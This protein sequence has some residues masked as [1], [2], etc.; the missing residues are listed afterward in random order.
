MSSVA[1]LCITLQ[2]SSTSIF[3]EKNGI[4]RAIT[5]HK[6]ACEYPTSAEWGSIGAAALL[7]RALRMTVTET[8]RALG[9]VSYHGSWS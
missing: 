9:I 7:V 3:N 1:S 2:G 8:R 6:T 4:D 5:V